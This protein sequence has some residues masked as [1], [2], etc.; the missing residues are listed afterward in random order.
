MDRRAAGVGIAGAAALL[1]WALLV[2]PRRLRVRERTLRVPRWP[3]ELD[4]LRVAVLADLHAGAP[5]VDADKL[6]RVVRATARAR[7][8]LVVLLG[9][10]LVRD[11]AMGDP[12][13]AEEAT[14][15][16]AGVAAP[17]GAFAVLGNHDWAVDPAGVWAGL[18]RAGFEVLENRAVRVARGLWVAGVADALRRRPDVQSTLGQVTDDGPVLLLSHSP[19][20]FGEVPPRVSLTLAGHTHGGQVNLP[21][22]RRLVIDSDYTSGPVQEGGRVMFV[23]SGI[24]TTRL[25]ARLR[26]TPEVTVLR[27]EPG[28]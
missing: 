2:E 9:D 6:R 1:A 19:D 5:F 4:G 13:G 20:V 16:L 23:S 24:G 27:L 25:A 14:A 26:A 21:L 22:L 17:L 15:A 18:R 10:V 7:P 3:A 8:D 28:G 11:V 12:L